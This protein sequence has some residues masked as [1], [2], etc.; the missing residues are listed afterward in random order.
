MHHAHR[1]TKSSASTP[2][3]YRDA[4]GLGAALKG[5]ARGSAWS[6][7]RRGSTRCDPAGKSHALRHCLCERVCH[8]LC[9]LSGCNGIAPILVR[10]ETRFLLFEA[11]VSSGGCCL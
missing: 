6:G 3:L 10:Q 9:V 11:S 7:K 1:C 5:P 8:S 2:I 4:L